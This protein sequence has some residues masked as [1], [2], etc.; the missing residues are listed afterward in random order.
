MYDGS[1]RFRRD[2]TEKSFNVVCVLFELVSAEI[3]EEEH[4]GSRTS[5]GGDPVCVRFDSLC[6][7][8]LT[9]D[10]ENHLVSDRLLVLVVQWSR[11]DGSEDFVEVDCF[12]SKE[13]L[14]LV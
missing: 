12:S 9:H 7:P 5:P 3:E 11:V 10:L 4:C 6:C 8:G 13:F 1:M 14:P 2:G